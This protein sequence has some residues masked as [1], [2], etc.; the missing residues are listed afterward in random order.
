MQEFKEAILDKNIQTQY[1]HDVVLTSM[2]RRFKVMDVAWTSKRRRA[3]T[4][5]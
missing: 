2:R 4:G 3:L 5:E 1:T